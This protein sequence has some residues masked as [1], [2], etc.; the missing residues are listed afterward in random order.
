MSKE[1]LQ[2]IRNTENKNEKIG[3]L[4]AFKNK[5]NQVRIGWS[6]VHGT[7]KF[8]KEMGLKIARGRAITGRIR[9]VPQPVL[10]NIDPFLLRCEKYFAQN[11]AFTHR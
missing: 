1:I 5:E 8:N 9:H 7:D 6:F 4:V 3:V 11:V 2:Y 10:D